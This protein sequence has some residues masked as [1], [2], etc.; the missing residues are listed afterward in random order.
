MTEKRHRTIGRALVLAAFFAIVSVAG[1]K[2]LLPPRLTMTVFDVGQGDA[3]MLRCGS[4]ETL[5]DGGPDDTVLAKIG[6]ALPP[7]ERTIERIILTHPH[8]DHY[9]GLIAVLSRYRVNQFLYAEPDRSHDPEYARLLATARDN[10][11]PMRRIAKG[12]SFD[13][14]TCARL[15]TLW[16][17]PIVPA[18]AV[19][20]APLV[21]PAHAGIHKTKKTFDPNED[22][23]VLR[24]T[25]PGAPRALALLMGDATADTEREIISRE[26]DVS[27]EVLKVGHHGSA[28]STSSEFVSVVEPKFAV[29]SVAAKNRYGH[30]AFIALERLRRLGS[31]IYRTDQNGDVR[32]VFPLNAPSFVKRKK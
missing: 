30:P 15:E 25:R 27:A 22:S 31:T 2:M 7:Y 12:D 4:D 16:P 8:R 28:Y 29:A 6:N 10:G 3:I 17:P 13:V 14:G 26:P 20:T 9:I 21:I 23:I 1:A 24:M 5:I 19:T 11:V 18:P 32:I